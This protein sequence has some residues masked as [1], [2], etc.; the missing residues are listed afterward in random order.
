MSGDRIIL[1]G[2]I[3]YGMHG[4]D[5]AEK[6]LGQRFIVDVEIAKDL[7]RPGASDDVDDTINYADVYRMAKNVLEG[8][9]RNLIE[10]LAEDIARRIAEYWPRHGIEEIKVRV[11]K[12]EVPI[13]NSVLAAAAVEITRQPRIDYP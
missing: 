6:S 12:P 3:L 10:Y 8:P 13:K 4:V 1:E 9:S 2:M 11:R 5:P 7:R